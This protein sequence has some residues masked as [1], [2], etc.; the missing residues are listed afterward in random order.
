MAAM[1]ITA[2]VAVGA[3]AGAAAR[4]WARQLLTTNHAGVLTARP[5]AP[6][7]TAIVFG[8]LMW[9][10]GWTVDLL[11]YSYLAAIGVALGIIDTI[12][13]RL[14]NK[15]LLPSFGALAAFFAV[16]SIAN[17]DGLSFL[18]AVSASV[19]VAGFYLVLA[20]TSG[21]GLGAGDVKLGGLLGLALGWVD[22]Q[23]V[24]TGVL[25]GW[26]FGGVTWI[27]LRVTGVIPRAHLMPA[28][29]FLLLGAVAAIGFMPPI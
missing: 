11:G 14:P 25:L 2:W 3:F 28:G 18:R 6:L 19:A 7:L 9:R 21:G 23:V 4:I 15:M 27:V 24:V 12:E 13:H 26:C 5:T 1:L 8:F 10:L 29:P 16:L 20:L 22:W 17:A